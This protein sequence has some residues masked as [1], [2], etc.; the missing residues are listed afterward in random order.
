M[1]RCHV[2]DLAE[3]FKNEKT[4]T[5]IYGNFRTCNEETHIETKDS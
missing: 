4:E 2:S 5:S 1:A 3:D